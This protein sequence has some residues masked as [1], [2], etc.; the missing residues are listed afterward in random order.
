MNFATGTK[1]FSRVDG[2][3]GTILNRVSPDA[4][5]VMTDYGIEVW[6]DEDIQAV[7]EG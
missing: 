5:E 3:P 4:W 7:E 6:R 2:E 1:V